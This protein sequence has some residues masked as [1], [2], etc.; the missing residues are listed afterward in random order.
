MEKFCRFELH[1][2]MDMYPQE[3][4]VTFKGE[5]EEEIA[6]NA[7]KWASEMTKNYSG[8]PTRFIKVMSAEEA[9]KYID[10]QI[11]K[12]HQNWQD[13]SQEFIDRIT[14]LYKKCYETE[15]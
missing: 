6:S 14:N 10:E 12:E 9:K 1:E 2:Y 13:D 11:A 3:K 5:T 7:Q 8:G 15:N 4:V